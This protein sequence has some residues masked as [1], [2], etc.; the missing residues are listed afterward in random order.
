MWDGL[1]AV[2]AGL[3]LVLSFVVWRGQK[4]GEREQA[5]LHKEQTE[6]QRRMAVIE[7]ARRED[8]V[9]ARANEAAM[10]A[11]ADVRPTELRLVLPGRAGNSDRLGLMVVNHGPA[12]A[13][14]ISVSLRE[15]ANRA[16]SQHLQGLVE[17]VDEYGGYGGESQLG[18]YAV[19][20]P[21]LDQLLPGSSFLFEFWLRN[22]VVGVANVR[23]AWEDDR[24]PQVG[25]FDLR[26]VGTE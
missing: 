17:L 6:L 21:E 16:V 22:R 26:L 14:R 12:V 2:I 18:Y 3:A 15:S 24:G 19:K 10:Q 13:R 23:L 25:R 8:E 5:A 11:V 9:D 7:E 1:N 4:R 20:A